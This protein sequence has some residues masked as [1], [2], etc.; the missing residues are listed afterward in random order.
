LIDDREFEA[1]REELLRERS[2]LNERRGEGEHHA[3]R[4]FELVENTL[5]FA[6]V[7][8]SRFR[9]GSPDKKR[10][11]LETVGSNLSLKDKTLRFEP[12]APF[13]YLQNVDDVS[14]W[15]ATVEDVRTYCVDAPTP[16]RVLIMNDAKVSAQP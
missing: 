6:Q 4:W 14:V 16:F 2:Y 12:G 9:E 7:A 8:R 15:R 13:K 1:K 3:D 11:I 5:R 10:L